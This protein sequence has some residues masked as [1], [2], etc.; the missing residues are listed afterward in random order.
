MNSIW[1]FQLSF[2]SKITPSTFIDFLDLIVTFWILIEMGGLSFR[3]TKQISVLLSLTTIPEP[4]SHF[5]IISN[6]FSRLS[7]ATW[8]HY[9]TQY[10][11]CCLQSVR[12]KI[13]SRLLG[14]WQKQNVFWKIDHFQWKSLFFTTLSWS[15]LNQFFK[16]QGQGYS[17][18]PGFVK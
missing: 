13:W 15:L 6:F 4:L 16:S 17:W 7:I 10:I 9:S 8:D 5:V 1:T 14:S 18:L 2:E 3:W 11:N 12:L